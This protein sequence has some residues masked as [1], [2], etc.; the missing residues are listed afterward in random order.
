MAA[1]GRPVG[2]RQTPNGG[3]LHYE[4]PAVVVIYDRQRGVTGIMLGEREAGAI[5]GE[6]VGD[7]VGGARSRWGKPTETTAEGTLYF[8]RG[9]WY[10][11]VRP[12][13]NLIGSIGIE[14]GG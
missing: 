10:I 5:E 2:V 13:G 9:G 7:A 11:V 4:T 3:V 6:R 12:D 8:Y 1:L 14:A